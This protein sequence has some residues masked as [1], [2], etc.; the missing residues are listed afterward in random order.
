MVKTDLQIPSRS[1]RNE[2]NDR[3]LGRNAAKL[4]EHLKAGGTFAKKE[5]VLAV[6]IVEDHLFDT[7]IVVTVRQSVD[8]TSIAKSLGATFADGEGASTNRTAVCDLLLIGLVAGR[9]ERKG[10]RLPIETAAKQTS[11]REKERGK[12]RKRLH[13]R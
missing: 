3:V 9:A 13:S 1:A 4:Q 6:L 5:L 2:G 11:F 8:E 12:K 10:E 7:P